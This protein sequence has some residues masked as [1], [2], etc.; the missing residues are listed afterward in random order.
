MS[1]EKETKATK[2]TARAIKTQFLSMNEAS[3]K[4]GG[5]DTLRELM[6]LHGLHAYVRAIGKSAKH[7]DCEDQFAH[8]T[9]CADGQDQFA[10]WTA[11][12]PSGADSCSYLLMG[13]FQLPPH[14][15]AKLASA[16]ESSQRICVTTFFKGREFGAF[17]FDADWNDVCFLAE[18]IRKV[19]ESKDAQID[20][21]KPIDPRKQTSLL[22]VVRALSKMA[23]L[24]DEGAAVAIQKQLEE[25]GFGNGPK[26]A[27]I[28]R[29]L[30]EARSLDLDRPL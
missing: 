16:V 1:A 14:Q 22:R 12:Y 18:D 28:R 20:Q 24:P 23:K 8:D 3:T 5:E 15:F 29:I 19:G 2:T 11:H 10:S 27:A 17:Y 26:E 4:V 30:D 21:D 6:A 13:Y 9:L 25:I 7:D